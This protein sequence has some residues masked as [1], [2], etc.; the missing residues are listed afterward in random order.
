VE[1]IAHLKAK[2]L[3][4]TT[5]QDF[6]FELNTP[7]KCDDIDHLMGVSEDPVVVEPL[8]VDR[9]RREEWKPVGV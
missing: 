1:I 2:L 9:N 7:A 8:R 6:V 4:S 5:K 3:Y